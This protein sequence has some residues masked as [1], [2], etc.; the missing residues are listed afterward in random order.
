MM[1]VLATTFGLLVAFSCFSTDLK[2]EAH[3][4][5]DSDRGK[6]LTG[7]GYP[8]KKD[9]PFYLRSAVTKAD[10]TR[11][12]PLVRDMNAQRFVQFIERVDRTMVAYGHGKYYDIVPEHLFIRLADG[13]LVVRMAPEP[14]FNPHEGQPLTGKSRKYGID[15]MVIDAY[16]L[17]ANNNVAGD[18]DWI[19]LR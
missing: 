14:G 6:P 11:E 19:P 2:S 1:R 10:A 3:Q 15:R 18:W 9:D 7:P 13:L 8:V 16:F 5:T 12:F 17:D 4:K